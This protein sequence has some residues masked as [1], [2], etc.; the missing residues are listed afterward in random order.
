MHCN[1]AA[2]QYQDFIMSI[3]GQELLSVDATNRDKPVV[4]KVE[5][6]WFV[7]RIIPVGDYLLQLARG[8]NWY[9]GEQRGL[10]RV[11]ARRNPTTRWAV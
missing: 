9:F 2:H 6:A 4:S 11:A 3:S 8:S 10:L 1:R 7:D 5:L